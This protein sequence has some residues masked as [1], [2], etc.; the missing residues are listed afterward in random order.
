VAAEGLNDTLRAAAELV[1]KADNIDLMRQL[2]KAQQ[3]A[4]ELLEENRGLK[5]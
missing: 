4:M 5:E 2:L 1:Q 3:D